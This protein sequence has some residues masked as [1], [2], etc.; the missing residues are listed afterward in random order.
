MSKLDEL[1]AQYCPDGVEYVKIKDVCIKI[2]SGGTPNTSRSDY[3]GGNIPWLRTQ[4]VDWS[5]IIDTE[6]KITDEGLQNS[7]AKWIPENCVIVAMYG[8]TA[9]KV[10]INKIPLTTNQAC[11]NLQIDANKAMYRYVYYWLASKYND[12]KAL[13]QGS[14]SNINAKVIR[15]FPIPLPPLPVQQEIVRILDNFTELTTELTKKLTSET[16]ARR[17][18]YEYYRDKLLT[19]GDEVPVVKLGEIAS[20]S[21]SHVNASEL[22]AE[23]YIGVDNLLPDRR[24]KTTSNYVPS[25]GRLTKF[26]RGNILIGNIR[27][28]L[29]KIWLATSEGGT[30]GDVLVICLNDEKAILPKYLYFVLSSDN[31]FAYDM[32]NSKGAKMPRGD[33]NAIMKYSVPIPPISEQARIVSILDRFDALCNDLTSGLPAEI[34]ARQKQY[35]Y[36]RDKLLTFPARPKDVKEAK[37]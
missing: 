13:G 18:Q 8:V 29:K 9:A 11:C 26:E 33:K 15:D 32:Q 14:Q 1:I 31:F 20:Y 35:E 25:E 27:P 37:E 36:Y 7:S 12:L 22:D 10:A 28:Y 23:T 17:K 34:E 3:Y 5:D 4:E 19:F 21:K 6:V 2:S 24:G 16:T 30:N